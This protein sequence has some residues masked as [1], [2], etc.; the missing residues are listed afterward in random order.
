MTCREKLKKEHPRYVNTL[1]AGGAKGCPHYYGYAVKPDRCTSCED[2][3]DR[4]IPG[5][6]ERPTDIY[7]ICDKIARC[8]NILMG[9]GF[10]S[11]EAYT[12]VYKLIPLIIS[13]SSDVSISDVIKILNEEEQK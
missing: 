1:Y 2:C 3:W 11:S 12:I 4:E 8:R 6:E 7:E 10:T 13:Q 5:T 9:N